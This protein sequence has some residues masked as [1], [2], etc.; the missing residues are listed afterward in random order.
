MSLRLEP[1]W[2]ITHAL[3]DSVAPEEGQEVD[4]EALNRL[5]LGRIT[6][7]SGTLRELEDILGFL[8]SATTIEHFRILLKL[9]IVEWATISDVAAHLINEVLDLGYQ[10]RD[11]SLGA[12]VKNRHVMAAGITDIVKRHSPLVHYPH[13]CGMR[14]DIV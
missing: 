13:Y 12:I 4:V 5:G 14:N 9:Y 3:I 11:V 2:R 8:E 1:F 6:D 10:D 7:M